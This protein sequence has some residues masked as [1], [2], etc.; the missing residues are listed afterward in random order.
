MNIA[1]LWG[2]DGSWYTDLY[3]LEGRRRLFA[4]ALIGVVA[5][6]SWMYLSLRVS[7]STV[8]VAVASNSLQCFDAANQS[9]QVTERG[10]NENQAQFIGCGGFL[11]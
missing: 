9:P 2:G 3:M 6:F 8:R 1:G 5:F 11:P 4:V 7:T 10:A